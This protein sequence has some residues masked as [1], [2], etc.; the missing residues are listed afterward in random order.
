MTACLQ[1]QVNQINAD[2][3][4][5][6]GIDLIIH[7]LICVSLWMFRAEQKKNEEDL[8]FCHI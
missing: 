4:I 7:A 3:I 1:A 2:K 6:A 8:V 5:E